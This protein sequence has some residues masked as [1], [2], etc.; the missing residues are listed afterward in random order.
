MLREMKKLLM[1][2]ESSLRFIL[3]L[4]LRSPFGLFMTV[5]QSMFLQH[6]FNSIEQ[7]D[8]QRLVVV[9]LAFGVASFCLF[10]YNGTIWSIYAPFVVRMEGRLRSK[11]F[12]KISNFSYERIEATSH[13]EWMTRLNT[14]VQMPFSQPIHLPHA[15]NSI[16]Q[17]GVSA[18]IL[19]RINSMVF[20]WAMLFVIPHILTS[21]IIIA[22]VMPKLN[23][24]Y[25]EAIAVNTGELA[26]LITCADV[27]ALYDGHDYLMKRFENS[28]LNLLRTKIKIRQWNALNAGIAILPFGL[29][30]YLVLLIVSGGWIAKGYFTFGDLTAA[31]QYRHGVLVGS[32][33]LINSMISIQ[34]SMVGIRRINEMMYEKTEDANG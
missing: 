18:I 27:A 20:G 12:E 2:T 3:L 22:G 30:A 13:G 17:I 28:S 7:N 25:L 32:M 10:L 31:F 14:D 9:C 34:A 1:I 29:S 16:L 23:R 15:V 33:M 24:K 5:M 11:L 26:S 19:W 8:A 4:M 6:T 21:Q